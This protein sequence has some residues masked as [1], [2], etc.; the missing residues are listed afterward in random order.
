M[1]T[2]TVRKATQ[3]DR[4]MSAQNYE[5]LPVEF[6]RSDS[7]T[8]A[9][10]LPR[11]ITGDRVKSLQILSPRY[12]SR[13]ERKLYKQTS[14]KGNDNKLLQPLLE[15]RI[16]NVYQKTE[17]K[18]LSPGL[19]PGI[20]YEA[21]RLRRFFDAFH[22]ANFPTVEFVLSKEPQLVVNAIEP[23]TGHNLFLTSILNPCKRTRRKLLNIILG[24]LEDLL[25]PGKQEDE[26]T[27]CDKILSPRDN[28]T[29]RDCL[30]WTL[31]LGYTQEGLCLLNALISSVDF[32]KVDNFGDTYLHLAIQ[33]QSVRLIKAVLRKMS[34]FFLP[35]NFVK[36][37][38]GQTPLD[39]ARQT[40]N[41]EL[42]TLLMTAPTLV[43]C[44]R[45]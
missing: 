25:D 33:G 21:S 3:E 18:F 23:K 38:F 26:S 14:L 15:C 9:H 28:V 30:A 39:L 44:H 32:K 8:K 40:D 2:Q 34:E 20:P 19:K 35:V 4:T 17:F 36:N 12:Q 16:A 37:N 6:L 42:I 7:V 5:L 10:R 43:H 45:G 41:S 11:E 13:P 1:D 31:Y 24:R 29:G 22:T 27:M